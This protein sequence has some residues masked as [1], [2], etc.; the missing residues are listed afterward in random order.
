MATY[1][2]HEAKTHLSKL[3]EKAAQ[4]EEVVITRSGEP[5]A[6]LSA[7]PPRKGGGLLALEGTWAHLDIDWDTWDDWDE[8]ERR[9]F[10][11]DG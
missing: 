4:G 3:V 8:E 11:M 1:G 5:V 2:M 9:A 7:P 10:G 6:I